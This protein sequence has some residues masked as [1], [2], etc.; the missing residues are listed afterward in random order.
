MR[1]RKQLGERYSPLY[2]LASLGSGG[3]AVTFFM[4]LV[5][6]VP[7]EGRPI[8]VFED[9]LAALQQGPAV[10]Q[11]LVVMSLAGIIWYRCST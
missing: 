2:F 1:I 3:L 10:R 9:I 4:F 11:T 7:H 5:F 6:M 8:P